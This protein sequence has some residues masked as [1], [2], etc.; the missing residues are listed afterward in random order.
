MLTYTRLSDPVGGF[1]LTLGAWQKKE[2]LAKNICQGR[3]GGGTEWENL[4]ILLYFNDGTEDQTGT[5]LQ[6][7]LKKS[8][9]MKKRER[10]GGGS[11]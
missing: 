1:L 11:Q 9:R 7:R 8:C 10:L 2:N 3:G 4:S 6:I 5:F